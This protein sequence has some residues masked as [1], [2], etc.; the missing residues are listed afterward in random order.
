MQFRM[1]VSIK[2]NTG[3]SLCLGFIILVYGIWVNWSYPFNYV[4]W[5]WRSY[6]PYYSKGEPYTRLNNNTA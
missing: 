2:E 6:L 5:R 3:V 1:N 4:E